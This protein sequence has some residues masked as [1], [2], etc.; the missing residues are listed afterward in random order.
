M[1]TIL[2]PKVVTQATKLVDKRTGEVM[3]EQLVAISHPELFTPIQ[4]KVLLDGKPYEAGTYEMAADS[5]TSGEYGRPAFRLKL[6][7][8]VK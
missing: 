4:A 3:Q 2:I 8:K 6:G 7:K 1:Y 5:L